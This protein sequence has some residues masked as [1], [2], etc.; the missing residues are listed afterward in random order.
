M[1]YSSQNDTSFQN[2]DAKSLEES[3]EMVNMALATEIVKG[4]VTRLTRNCVPHAIF[5]ALLFLPTQLLSLV[6]STLQDVCVK[7]P[8]ASGLTTSSYSA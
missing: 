5:A 4:C 2:F 6:S 7:L 3:V 1:L 8:W